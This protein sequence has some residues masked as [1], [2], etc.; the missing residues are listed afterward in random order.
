MIAVFI[1][2][3]LALEAIILS[4]YWVVALIGF[5]ARRRVWQR[6]HTAFGQQGLSGPDALI[7]YSTQTQPIIRSV[8]IWRTLIPVF[9]VIATVTVEI[10][11]A[12]VL[13]ETGLPISPPVG[14]ILL[15]AIGLTLPGTLLTRHLFDRRGALQL[16][17]PAIRDFMGITIPQQSLA[18]THIWRAVLAY[19]VMAIVLE[20]LG[21]SFTTTQPLLLVAVAL[22]FFGGVFG[23]SWLVTRETL[24]RV[25]HVALTQTPWGALDARLKQWGEA[26]GQ[27]IDTIALT[28]PIG[29]MAV[30]QM[31][32]VAPQTTLAIDFRVLLVT[33]W[34]QRDALTVQQLFA[35]R[36]RRRAL[37]QTA[38]LLA[39]GS[40]VAG[41]LVSLVITPVGFA[42]PLW[43]SS[44]LT[45]IAPFGLASLILGWLTQRFRQTTNRAATQSALAADA[46]AAAATGDPVALMV[47]LHTLRTLTPAPRG[48]YDALV[49]GNDATMQRIMALDVLAHRPDAPRAPWFGSPVPAAIPLML[50]PYLLTTAL[51]SPLF[52]EQPVMLRTA[53]A[54]VAAR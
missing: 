43:L 36:T 34:R 35:A 38:L 22:L 50:G 20:G 6:F 13:P 30:P 23:G 25:Y 29:L 44:S 2:A 24:R 10:T 8:A 1:I 4:A 33:D 52:P 41:A 21:V 9:T 47:A 39:L 42:L 17:G 11:L 51:A 15:A 54:P 16:D 48:R 12:V 3:T 31:E 14:G 37:W 28:F 5:G 26:L 40:S 32:I 7:G 53:V 27:P 19:F 46:A 45:A 18:T 49:L